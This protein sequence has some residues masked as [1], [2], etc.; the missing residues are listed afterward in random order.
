MTDPVWLIF[1]LVERNRKLFV[2]SNDDERDYRLKWWLAWFVIILLIIHMGI[3]V[4]VQ[5]SPFQSLLPSATIPRLTNSFRC[6]CL[7]K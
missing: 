6:R 3:L 1:F 4:V 2:M 5:V 7:R